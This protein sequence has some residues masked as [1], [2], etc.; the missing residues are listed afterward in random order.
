MDLAS[1]DDLCLNDDADDNIKSI[2]IV[3]EI[4][5]VDVKYTRNFANANVWQA[6]YVPFDVSL[7][8]MKVAGYE[9]A[10]IHAV[11]LDANGGA[12]I[13]FLK[14]NDGIVRA[15]T[16]YVVRSKTSG[17]VVLN[18]TTDL[19]PTHE[20]SF[21]ITSTYDTYNFGGVYERMVG[22]KWYALNKVGQFQLMG[23]GVYLR[24]FRFWMTINPYGDDSSQSASANSKM[25]IVVIED[26]ETTGIES[27]TPIR[28]EGKGAIYN[29]NGQR[30]ES[31]RSGQIYIMNGK[32]Y[33]AK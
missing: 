11:L 14:L 23:E 6:W 9:V 2:R 30:I 4:T 3:E 13:A 27:L 18:I 10:Q 15:N 8:D 12:A 21:G 19:Q 20:T 22:N 24:P 17:D 31:L 29:L 5:G 1:G 28:S 26:G 7:E 25:D 33:I 32:K 16:P